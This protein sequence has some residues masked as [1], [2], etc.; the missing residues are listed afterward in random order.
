VLHVKDDGSYTLIDAVIDVNGNAIFNVDSLSSFVV[1]KHQKTSVADTFKDVKSGDWFEGYVQYVYDEGLMTG[2]TASEFAPGGG[3]SRAMVVTVLW[4][5]AG[6]K[7]GN[8][9]AGFN[10]LTQ[11]WIRKPSIGP[12]RT[13]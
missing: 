10:D 1:L 8:A 4:R 9:V 2:V 11:D 12:T 6:G 3:A 7:T 13:V 5:M